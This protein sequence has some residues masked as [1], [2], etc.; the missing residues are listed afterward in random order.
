MRQATLADA[1][2]VKH[3]L[4]VSFRNDPHVNWLL[5]ESKNPLKLNVL[6]D[7][8][9]DQTL[10]RGEIYLS[11]SNDAVALWDSERNEKMSLHSIYRNLAFLIQIGIKPVMRILKSEG[12][13]HKNFI[14]FPRFCH[15]YLI[16]VLPEAQGKGLASAL[17]N[18]MMQRMKEQSIPAFLETA[19][20]R[21]VEI[22]KKKGFSVFQT[23]TIGGHSLF[24]MSTGIQESGQ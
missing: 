3:I 22:Y 13:I 12:I 24:L 9:V 19:N 17:M 7:Y 8:V 20:L 4:L 5:E 11:D 23:L 2:R 18:P 6:I 15:L 1:D 21:N 14:R 16:G 10:R